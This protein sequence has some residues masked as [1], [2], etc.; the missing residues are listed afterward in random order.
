MSYCNW[1]TASGAT[2]RYHDDCPRYQELISQ[3]PTIEK[4]RYLENKISYYG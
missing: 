4:R 1:D 2:R 3:Y